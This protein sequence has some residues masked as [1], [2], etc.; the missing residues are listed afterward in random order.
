M[1]KKNFEHSFCRIGSHVLYG[2]TLEGFE[3]DEE[4]ETNF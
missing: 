4:N 1:K 2:V 3:S